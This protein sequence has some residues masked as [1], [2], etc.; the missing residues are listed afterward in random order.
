[1]FRNFWDLVST[2]S[3]F[4]CMCLV[5]G[6]GQ[7]AHKDHIGAKI[8]LRTKIKGKYRVKLSFECM[9]PRYR[10]YYKQ[11]TVLVLNNSE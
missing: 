9:L 2:I 11:Q 8:G 1:M 5:I 4:V 6:K 3:I 7:I 10:C